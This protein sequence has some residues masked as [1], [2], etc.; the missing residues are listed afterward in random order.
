[1]I[2][3]PPR[4][5]LFPYTT[6]FRSVIDAG[7]DDVH[8]V[9]ALR[10]VLVGPEHPRLR[11]QRRAL[12]VAVP[13][14][15]FLGLPS[16]LAGEGVVLRDAAIVVQPDHRAGVVIRSLRALLLPALAEREIQIA[17]AVEDDAAAKVDAARAFRALPE[18][19]LH[20]LELPAIQLCT[21]EL[22]PDAALSAGGV[23]KINQSVLA[24]PGVENHIEKPTL[25]S[26]RDLRQPGNRLGI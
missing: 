8:L 25:P 7:T 21:R 4:S 17:V 14:V 6:L 13:E 19:H 24:V 5:T 1:M 11:M 10:P 15:E 23:R 20:F 22:G 16:R 2:R 26:G 12:H 18:Q 3:R 9:A